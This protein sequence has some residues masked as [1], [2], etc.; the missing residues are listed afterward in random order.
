[1]RYL[2]GSFLANGCKTPGNKSVDIK[3]G[4]YAQDENVCGA[5]TC[6]SKNGDALIH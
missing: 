3:V 5:Y 6:Q 1:M 2:Y 4:A